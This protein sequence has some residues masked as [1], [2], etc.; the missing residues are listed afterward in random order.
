MQFLHFGSGR[1]GVAKCRKNIKTNVA[2]LYFLIKISLS[3]AN[4]LMTPYR[5]Y[6]PKSSF[7]QILMRLFDSYL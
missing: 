3:I 6:M 5:R 1:R 4:F 7:K 2:D